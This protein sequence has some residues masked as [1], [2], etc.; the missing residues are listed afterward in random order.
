MPV[1][2]AV[3]YRVEDYQAGP[4]GKHRY[5]FFYDDATDKWLSTHM[6]TLTCGRNAA[7][8]SGFLRMVN[9]IA[10]SSTQGYFP[11]H[12]SVLVGFLA[13]SDT[14]VSPSKQNIDIY[15][16][17]SVVHTEDFDSTLIN[18]TLDIDFD[19]NQ[20]IAVEIRQD[21]P[22]TTPVRHNRPMVQL[23]WRWRLD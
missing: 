11:I 12:D 6:T 2:N 3:P 22:A 5:Y 18:R 8:Y 16:G 10:M 21:V 17:G 20:R 7:A 9:G 19:M 15:I 1:E 13:S 4:V 23:Y 14:D